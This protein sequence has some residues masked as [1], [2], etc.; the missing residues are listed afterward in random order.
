MVSRQRFRLCTAMGAA[1][2]AVVVGG[3]GAIR[4]EGVMRR[5]ESEEEDVQEAKENTQ[6]N[7]ESFNV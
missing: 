2:G 3:A 1:G 6:G 4:E 7:S 5:K